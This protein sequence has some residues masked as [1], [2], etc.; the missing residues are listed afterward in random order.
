MVWLPVIILWKIIDLLCS[1]LRCQL[2]IWD[3]L[4]CKLLQKGDKISHILVFIG[5]KLHL[6]AVSYNGKYLSLMVK[7]TETKAI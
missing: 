3:M 2:S 5:S 7:M 1:N 6:L 4:I